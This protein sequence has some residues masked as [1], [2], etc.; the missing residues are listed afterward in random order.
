MAILRKLDRK[1]T[2]Q[3][4]TV[5]IFRRPGSETTSLECPDGSKML[6]LTTGTVIYVNG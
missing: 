6:F 5:V 4:K 3:E 1:K 2:C